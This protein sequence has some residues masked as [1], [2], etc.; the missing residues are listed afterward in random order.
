MSV[1]AKA[2]FAKLKFEQ[3]LNDKYFVE[4]CFSKKFESYS[5]KQKL[6]DILFSIRESDKCVTFSEPIECYDDI[7]FPTTTSTSTT[8]TTT[9]ATT[10]TTTSS[11]TSTSSTTTTSTEAPIQATC[12]CYQVE[13]LEGECNVDW[14]DCDGTPQT[15]PIGG[16]KANPSVITMCA[17]EGSVSPYCL[18]PANQAQV[19]GGID[20]CLTIDDCPSNN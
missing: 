12:Y 10:T 8:T 18:T 4:T 1:N 11:T 5:S 2:S 13:I 17:Q 9:V 14:I 19:L 6:I 20:P 15:S 16:G 7:V 3:L